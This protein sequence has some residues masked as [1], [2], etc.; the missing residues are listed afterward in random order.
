MA[1]DLISRTQI[2]ARDVAAPHAAEVDAKARFPHEAIEAARQEKLLSAAVPEDLGGAGASMSELAS[3]CTSMA[4]ACASSGM[5]LAMH[6]IQVAC[7][8]RHGRSSEFFN[9]YLSE[10]AQQQLLLA[11]VTSEV[12]TSGETRASICALQLDGDRFTLEKDATTVSYGEYADGLLVTSRR[13]SDA[14]QNDQLLVLLRKGDYALQRTSEWDT[15]G[16]RGTCSPGFRLTSSA[17][18]CQIIPGSFAD[19]SS[20][21]MV[22]FSHVLWSA[23]WLGIASDAVARASAFVRADARR[24]PGTVPRTAGR[25]AEVSAMLQSLR[26]NVVSVASDFDALGTNMDELGTMGWALRLNNLKIAASEAA[27]QIVHKTLQICGIPGYRNDTPFSVGRNYR[28]ALS[29]SLMIANDRI[30]SKSA[31]MLLV[32]KDDQVQ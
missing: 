5:V 29:A 20:Q 2:I 10:L 21:T 31:S 4:Q 26:N 12:G 13:S 32:Y 11:S 17:P 1:H 30:A 7:M 14:P 23:V 8:S 25:L 6:Y 27:P 28:D 24:Q 16:M 22:P 19:S 18:A 9:S 15:I 3:I